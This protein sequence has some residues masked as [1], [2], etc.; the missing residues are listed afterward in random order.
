VD[1]IGQ[2]TAKKEIQFPRINAQF[3]TGELPD[4]LIILKDFQ[5]FFKDRFPLLLDEAAMRRKRISNQCIL[6]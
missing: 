2:W 4:I 1:G 6:P 5:D 3:F